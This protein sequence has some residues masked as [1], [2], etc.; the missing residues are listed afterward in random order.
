MMHV[1]YRIKLPDHDYVVAEK[2]KLIPSVH[3]ACMLQDKFDPKKGNPVSYSGPT[4]IAI[5]SSGSSRE[6]V[7]SMTRVPRLPVGLI[8]TTWLPSL[9]SEP[10]HAQLRV[11]SSLWS[12]VPLMVD[13]M[14]TQDLRTPCWWL[15]TISQSTIRMP[16]FV[17]PMPGVDLPM[18]AANAVWP[19]CHDHWL[20]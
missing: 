4:Y 19:R 16:F 2:H 10:R 20:V 14:K 5:R 18:A 13:P 8:S 17:S 15:L 7:A 11:L 6:K 3:A 12:F 1:E 9:S